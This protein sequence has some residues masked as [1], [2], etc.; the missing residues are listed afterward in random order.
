MLGINHRCKYYGDCYFADA[1]SRTCT[2]DA[3]GDYCGVFR[4]LKLAQKLK[5]ERLK[6]KK[7]LEVA[8]WDEF[9]GPEYACPFCQV[10]KL[11]D[12]FKFCPMCGGNMEGYR[13]ETIAEEQKRVEKENE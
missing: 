6:K 3:G 11:C 12:D 8:H 4:V 9:W 5:E 13:F 7:I 2:Q 1:T 10:E